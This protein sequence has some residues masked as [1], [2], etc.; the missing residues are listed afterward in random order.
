MF[1]PP[2]NSRAV[3]VSIVPLIGTFSLRKIRNYLCTA[4]L[5]SSYFSGFTLFGIRPL[6][7]FPKILPLFFFHVDKVFFGTPKREAISLW[8]V[9]FSNS[10]SDL[11]FIFYDLFSAR[12][13]VATD[14]MIVEFQNVNNVFDK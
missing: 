7:Y 8:G 12:R 4:L 11:Y 5:S 3:F 10:L 1:I 14:V 6:L 2:A 13:F 9:P